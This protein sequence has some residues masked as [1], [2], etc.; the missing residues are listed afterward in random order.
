MISLADIVFIDSN[1]Y[2]STS[3]SLSRLKKFGGKFSC[4]SIYVSL[5][6]YTTAKCSGFVVNYFN[7]SDSYNTNLKL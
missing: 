3:D 5:S 1:S 7:Y 6:Y 4:A 2:Y